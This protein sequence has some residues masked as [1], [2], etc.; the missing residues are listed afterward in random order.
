MDATA[1][2]AD[3]EEVCEIIDRLELHR[4]CIDEALAEAYGELIDMLGHYLPE[5]LPLTLERAPR[6]VMTS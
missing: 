4:A 1:L 3:L 6:P 2:P 5:T